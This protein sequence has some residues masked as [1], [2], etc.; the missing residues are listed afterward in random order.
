MQNAHRQR[1]CDQATLGS[2]CCAT[3]ALHGRASSAALWQ[4]PLRCARRRPRQT[5]PQRRACLWGRPPARARCSCGSTARCWAAG[6]GCQAASASLA[7]AQKSILS[8]IIPTPEAEGCAA[9][10]SGTWAANAGEHYIRC[11]NEHGGRG[12]MHSSA[13]CKDNSTSYTQRQVTMVALCFPR[14]AVALCRMQRAMPQ[15]HRHAF[16][17]AP[18]GTLEKPSAIR[19]CAHCQTWPGAPF[20]GHKVSSAV[21]IPCHPRPC[22]GSRPRRWWRS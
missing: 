15:W 4:A 7:A 6:S 19:H 9:F 18:K 16:H 11:P 17:I 8:V 10:V 5:G 22:T 21:C 14:H 13:R 2:C 3:K 1:I 12:G 20:E